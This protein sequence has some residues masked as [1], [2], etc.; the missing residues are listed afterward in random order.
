MP[1]P[2]LGGFVQIIIEKSS[3]A[4][5]AVNDSQTQSEG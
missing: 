5:C 2:L 4:F 3:P 1:S